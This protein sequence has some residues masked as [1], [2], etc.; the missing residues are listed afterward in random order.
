[1]PL[2]SLYHTTIV[3]L[4]PI[5]STPCVMQGTRHTVWDNCSEVQIWELIALQTNSQQG[6]S[7]V[8]ACSRL[9]G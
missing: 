9:D 7:T 4:R 1:M 5:N 3:L 8:Y 2:T 6:L